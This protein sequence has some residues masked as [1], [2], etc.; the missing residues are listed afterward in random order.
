MAMLGEVV[1]DS[2]ERVRRPMMR[3]ALKVDALFGKKMG[4][5]L[6]KQAASI[7]TGG[8]IIFGAPDF[9]GPFSNTSMNSFQCAEVATRSLRYMRETVD[10]EQIDLDGARGSQVKELITCNSTMAKLRLYYSSRRRTQ[11]A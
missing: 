3:A 7:G 9:V 11:V 10:R 5:H 1:P 4:I 6:L 8:D 2:N